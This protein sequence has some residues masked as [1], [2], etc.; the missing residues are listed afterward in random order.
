MT[1]SGLYDTLD[2]RPRLRKLLVIAAIVLAYAIFNFVFHV[3]LPGITHV[4]LRPQ[5][6]LLFIA[7]YLYGPWYGFLAGFMGN[8]C[9]DFLIGF[10]W[11][12]L[13]SWTVGNGLIGALTG[14]FPYRKRIRLD[15]IAQLVWLVLFLI[16]VNIVSLAYAAGMENVLERGLALSVNFQ[17]FY[18]PALM[19]NILATLIL[20]PACLFSLGRLQRNYPVKL[21]L[22]NYYLT[23][24]VLLTVFW[25]ASLAINQDVSWLMASARA[26]L[27]MKTGNALV[28]MFNRWSLLAVSVLICSFLVSSWMSKIIVSPL[29]RLEDTVLA[30][31]EG[32]PAS[33][34]RLGR[35]VKRDDEI[36]ILSYAIR[37]LS[38]KLWETQALFRNELK[39]ALP[40]LDDR[41]SG[42]DVFVVSLL[43]LL[44]KEALDNDEGQAA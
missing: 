33:A 38:E 1:F 9:S 15:R 36:G 42:T 12:Y 4:D 44:G 19:S 14:L 11:K 30:V 17:Y 35:F 16:L 28:A 29:K 27:D 23:V 7:G 40:F 22:A 21:A 8:A 26:T 20:F 37:L 10:G 6:V 43:S 41:D 39:K 24:V 5:I 34:E 32:D 13:P 31:L 2:R 25:V 3:G 18:L